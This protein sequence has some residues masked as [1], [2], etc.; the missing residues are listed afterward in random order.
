MKIASQEIQTIVVEAYRSGKSSKRQLADIFGFHLSA[1]NKWIRDFTVED[2]LA[3]KPKGHMAPAFSLQERERLVALVKENPGMTL[4]EIKD[5]FSKSCSLMSVHRT[6]KRLG[7]RYKN[8]T[9]R[10]TGAGGHS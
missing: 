2:R 6:L 9:G 3:P 1:I 7:F 10:R 5:A 8:S 4:E